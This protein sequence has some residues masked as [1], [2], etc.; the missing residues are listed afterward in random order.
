MV[1]AR[2]QSGQWPNRARPC[3]HPLP[4]RRVGPRAPVREPK[5]QWSGSRI[6]SRGQSALRLRRSTA[7]AGIS[8]TGS[9]SCWTTCRSTARAAASLLANQSCRSYG[10]VWKGP[11]V[12]APKVTWL[13]TG[14][15]G[16]CRQLATQHRPASAPRRHGPGRHRLFRQEPS[17]HLASATARHPNLHVFCRGQRQRPRGSAR[18]HAGPVGD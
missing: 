8:R 4:G 1:V 7:S 15:A 13:P 3:R 10:C 14:M 18:G 2:A 6:A 5:Q 17:P 9:R 11:A 16:A 12:S